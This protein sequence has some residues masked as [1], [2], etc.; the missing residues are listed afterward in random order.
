MEGEEESK[1]SSTIDGEN[2]MQGVIICSG[3]Y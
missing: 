2:P 3:Q 1:G